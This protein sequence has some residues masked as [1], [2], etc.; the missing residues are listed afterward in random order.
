LN[1]GLGEP[2]KPPR[3]HNIGGHGRHHK[4]NNEQHKKVKIPESRLQTSSQWKKKV[5]LQWWNDVKKNRQMKIG[6]FYVEEDE[7]GFC[8]V[9]QFVLCIFSLCVRFL[10]DEKQL[11]SN[12]QRHG[13][14]YE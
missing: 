7:F 11:V 6:I 2:K 13:I 5:G 3:T 12:Q 1:A 14:G 8:C 10:E 4:T 9:L